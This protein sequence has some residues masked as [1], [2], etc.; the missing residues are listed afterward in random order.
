MAIHLPVLVCVYRRG[1]PEPVLLYEATGP[2]RCLIKIN[3]YFN[4]CIPVEVD[5][6]AMQRSY[7]VLTPLHPGRRQTPSNGVLRTPGLEGQDGDH[8]SSMSRRF[9]PPGSWKV[10]SLPLGSG[11][12]HPFDACTSPDGINNHFSRSNLTSIRS[13]WQTNW[14]SLMIRQSSRD[15]PAAGQPGEVSC[16]LGCSAVEAVG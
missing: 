2:A 10:R 6:P 15:A 9:W 7:A 11:I 4:S 3:P 16:G 13:D 1:L 8:R 5:P 12:S 14:R